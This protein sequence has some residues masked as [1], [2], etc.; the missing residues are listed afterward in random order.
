MKSIS[1]RRSKMF[2]HTM[3]FKAESKV[4]GIKG[5]IT[6]R[7]ENLYGCNRYFIQASVGADGKMPD[8]FWVDEDDISIIGEGVTAKPKD[9]GG[10]ASTIC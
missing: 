2:I 10:P 7:S 4:M 9:T 5:I 6:A 3:G 1:K 8:S